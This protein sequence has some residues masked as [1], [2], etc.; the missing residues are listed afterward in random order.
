M[1]LATAG[2]PPNQHPNANSTS[3][4]DPQR[5][6]AMQLATP[7][8]LPN[9]ASNAI[10]HRRVTPKTGAQTTRNPKPF[11]EQVSS[12]IC[13]RRA[14]PQ[15]GFQYNRP[16]QG[17][18]PPNVLGHCKPLP[19]QRPKPN[20]PYPRHLP[21]SFPMRLASARAFFS[22]CNWPLQGYPPIS[23]PT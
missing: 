1:Q 5:D 9:Q 8:A 17:H 23:T 13:Q 11:P 3:M 6:L 7:G 19:K 16:S 21:R 14:T 10:G 20:T 4:V 22:R 18:P 12:A 2:P 15:V